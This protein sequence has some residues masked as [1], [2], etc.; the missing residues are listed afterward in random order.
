MN[1]SRIRRLCGPNHHHPVRDQQ[2]RSEHRSLSEE[3]KQRFGIRDTQKTI[4]FFGRIKPY[5]G[6]EYLIAAFQR[7]AARQR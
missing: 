5:K 3:A 1:W 4:L 6:L 2:F 7:L